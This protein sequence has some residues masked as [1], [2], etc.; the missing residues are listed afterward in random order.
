MEKAELE[1]RK[2][3]S[4]TFPSENSLGLAEKR[5]PPPTPILLARSN[6]SMI[7]TPAP[8]ALEEEVVTSS[9]KTQF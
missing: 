2:L 7:F 5:H 6:C 8:Y 1:E 9:L 3:V 4:C